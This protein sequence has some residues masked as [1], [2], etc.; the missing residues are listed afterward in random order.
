M[1]RVHMSRCMSAGL[2]SMAIQGRKCS[3]MKGS[4]VQVLEEVGDTEALGAAKDI[5]QR[6]KYILAKQ[7]VEQSEQEYLRLQKILLGTESYAIFVLWKNGKAAKRTL[8]E[9]AE[10]SSISVEDMSIEQLKEEAKKY[11]KTIEA[12]ANQCIANTSGN[13]GE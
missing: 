5:Q 3:S 7:F 12:V 8:Q 2:Q 13:K 9:Y 1:F 11:Q 10:R 4:L 6:V